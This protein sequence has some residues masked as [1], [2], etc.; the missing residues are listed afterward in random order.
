MSVRLCQFTNSTSTSTKSDIF[1]FLHSD[2]VLARP[3]IEDKQLT[4]KKLT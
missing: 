2:H 3:F 1:Q 4:K